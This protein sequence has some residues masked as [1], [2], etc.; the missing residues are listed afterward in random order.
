M[1]QPLCLVQK[2]PRSTSI[3]QNTAKRKQLPSEDGLEEEPAFSG[4][5]CFS[6]QGCGGGQEPAECGWNRHGEGPVTHPLFP[7]PAKPWGGLPGCR[8]VV[9][10]GHIDGCNRCNLRSSRVSPVSPNPS[11]ECWDSTIHIGGIQAQVT[12]K[13]CAHE[14]GVS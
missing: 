10:T 14:F 11:T 2:S 7:L 3:L 6:G 5:I 9:V 13:V 1:L 4:C 12:W 8:W